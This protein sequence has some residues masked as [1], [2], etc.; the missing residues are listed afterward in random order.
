VRRTDTPKSPRP[1]NDVHAAQDFFEREDWTVFRTINGLQ[2]NAGVSRGKLPMLV[3]KELTDNAL[4]AGAKVNVNKLNGSHIIEDN[5]KGIEPDRVARLFSIRRSM[6]STK[7]LRLPQ[8]RGALGNGLR[9][10]AGAVLASGGSLTVTTRNR[11]ITLRPERDGS[12]TVV[13]SKAVKHPVGTRVEIVLGPSLPCDE[14]TLHWAQV[15]RHLASTGSTY[16]GKS[17]PHWF[18]V[19]AFQELLDAAGDKP[20]R[21]LMA[22][23]DG[24][25]DGEKIAT[26]ARL[27]RATCSGLDQKQAAKLLAVAQENTEPVNP[28][29]LGSVGPEAFPR[30][31]YAIERG[32]VRLD[33][34][35][36]PFVIEAWVK[37]KGEGK[38]QWQCCV[39]RTPITG[40]HYAHRDGRKI[41]FFSGDLHHNICSAPKDTQFDIWLNITVPYMPILSDGKAPSLMPFFGAI[42][43]VVGKAVR[44][45]GRP[46]EPDGGSLLPKRR[47]GNQSWEDDEAYREGV[48]KFCKLIQQ[49][50]ATL[51]FKVGSRGWCYLLEQ[52]DLHK[53]DFDKAENLITECRKSGDLPLDICAEDISRTTAV[54]EVDALGVPD[55]VESLID[56]LRNHEH[57]KYLPIILW[58]DLDVY[59]EVVVEKIDLFYLFKPVCD[60]FHVPITN[61]KS[62]SDINRRAEIL[63]RF[64]YWHA[65]GKKCVLL[66]CGDHDPGGL[67]ITDKL[68]SNLEDLKGAVGWSPS[69]ANLIISRFGLNIDFIEENSL[70]WIDNLETSSGLRLDDED[71]RDHNKDYVQNY[72]AEFGVRKCEA[73][74]L[75]IVPEVGRQLCRDAILEHI[76]I[77]AVEEYERKLAEL[78]EQLQSALQERVS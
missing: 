14:D 78:R 65:R 73:N 27:G 17:S 70:I 71:H 66:V 52:H 56:H 5:G 61:L 69:P 53:G 64:K 72:I 46:P 29:K 4:D 31:A 51:D 45:A 35:T 76:D 44:A 8:H 1:S 15:A 33:T 23:F 34:V 24:C 21:E 48:D 74:A 32:N 77:A 42:C 68:R 67:L 18:D 9:V 30:L 12:T 39:N 49:I 55:K 26:Q 13:R 3:M 50:N 20:V 40:N 22:L 58:D 6:L 54:E 10:V 36:I 57:E 43:N 25:G 11:R 38:T 75:V 2:Q 41:D 62:W 28:K 37:A 16:Q 7:L 47:R 60:E 63:L 19:Q 59:V